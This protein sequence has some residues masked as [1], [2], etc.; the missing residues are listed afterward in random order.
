[1]SR[2]V[3]PLF[4]GDVARGFRVLLESGEIEIEFT[5]R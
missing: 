5:G 3:P 4:C 2:R 1:M